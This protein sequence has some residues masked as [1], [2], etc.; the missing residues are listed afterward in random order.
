M[1]RVITGT[2]KGRKLDVPN[3]GTRPLTDRIKTSLFDL[4]RNRLPG[5]NVLDLYAG[6]GA[7][8]IETLSRGA[9]SCI[10]IDIAEESIRCIK[11][12]LN[13]TDLGEN[14]KV[15]QQHVND[16]ITRTSEMFN[17]I[18][19]DPPFADKS[20]PDFSGLQKILEKN[21]IIIY[22]T[23]QNK[24]IDLSKTK[25]EIIYQ[26]IYGKSKIFF[27]SPKEIL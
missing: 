10:F 2:A 13:N 15:F 4:I 1:I 21:G 27:I 26:K 23:V 9:N 6:S 14:A 7:F 11:N 3:F 12:N 22:R 25:L 8:G 18:F 5:S 19:L 16:F 20:D 17:L 24:N